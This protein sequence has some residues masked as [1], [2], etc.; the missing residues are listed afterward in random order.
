MVEVP[1]LLPVTV[2]VPSSLTAT[3]TL[4]LEAETRYLPEVVPISVEGPIKR[5]SL[6]YSL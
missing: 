6:L 3:S 4:S 1:A 5:P 2:I